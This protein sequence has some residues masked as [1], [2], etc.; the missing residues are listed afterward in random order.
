MKSRVNPEPVW[1]HPVAVADI[2]EEGEEITLAPDEETR[3]ALARFADVVAV[4]V[5]SARLYLQP[6][7]AGGAMVTGE[8][9][10]TV[11]QNSVVSLEPFENK[12]HEEIALRFAPEGA[13]QKAPDPDFDLD[14]SDPSDA[15]KNGVID[16]GAVVSEFLLLG[17]DPYPRKPGEVF[18]PPQSGD[19]EKRDNPFAALAK[20]KKGRS[21]K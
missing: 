11:K 10:A 7:G 17:I 20:L 12:V 1:N 3:A 9:N 4:P 8:L 6:D 2:P 18:T 5:L 15:I 13:V 14:E 16:L 19:G 21:S